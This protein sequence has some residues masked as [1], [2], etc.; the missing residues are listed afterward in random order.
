[1]PLARSLGDDA[2][3]SIGWPRPDRPDQLVTMRPGRVRTTGGAKYRRR[4]GYRPTAPPRSA[5][6]PGMLAK[7]YNPPT[8]R[9]AGVSAPF[10][11]FAEILQ[12][13]ACAPARV[14]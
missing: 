8:L 13:F 4:R 11:G 12:L 9:P 1:M 14:A 6:S 3:T 10:A 5:E 2:V 7:V